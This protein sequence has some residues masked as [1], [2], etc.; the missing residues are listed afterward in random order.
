MNTVRLGNI[1]IAEFKDFLE[2]KGCVRVDNG[3]EEHQ[4]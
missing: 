2:S 4:K 3:N 1:S